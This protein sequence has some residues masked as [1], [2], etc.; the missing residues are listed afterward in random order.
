MYLVI[1]GHVDRGKRSVIGSRLADRGALPEGKLAEIRNR[2]ARP[3][4]PFEYVVLFD[5]LKDEE[6]RVGGAL[7]R[8]TAGPRRLARPG[9]VAAV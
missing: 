4:R 7:R 1:G 3:P 2:C 6:S 9:Q 8:P 5:A